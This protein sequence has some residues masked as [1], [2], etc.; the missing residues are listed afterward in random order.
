METV[1]L[2]LAVVLAFLLGSVP[3]AV[4]VSK[5]MGLKD[6]R[7][8]GSGNPGATNVLRSGS[9]KAAVLT[10][11]LDAAKGWLPVALVGWFGGQWGLWEGAQAA[12]GFA[13]FA[14]HVWSIF[15]RFKGGKGVATALGVLLGISPWLGLWVL[16]TWILAFAVWRYSSLSSV[17]AAVLAPVFYLVAGGQFWSYDRLVLL[18]VIAMAAVLLYRHSANIGRLLRGTE[19]KVG[20]SKTAAD[21]PVVRQASAKKTPARRGGGKR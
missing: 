14:G 18:S 6:P 3:F 8:F 20:A 5:V 4:L 10:L 13:A 16:L 11:V 15:L 19:P 9:K 17:L 7:S 2:L 21:K 12:V 1:Y